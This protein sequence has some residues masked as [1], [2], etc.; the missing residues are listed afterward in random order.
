MSEKKE[1]ER[2]T[3]SS[4]SAKE[5]LSL[6]ITGPFKGPEESIVGTI[7]VNQE[8][9]IKCVISSVT[10]LINA[11]S[12][13]EGLEIKNFSQQLKYEGIRGDIRDVLNKGKII[14]K[15]VEGKNGRW[16]MLELR[17]HSPEENMDGVVITF[18]DITELKETSQILTEKIEKIKE[19]QR[20][21][22]KQDVS[23]RWRIGQFLHD[24]VGQTLVAADFLLQNVKKKL[25]AG[26]NG[27]EENIDQ[28]IEALKET[29][30][31][32]RDL[33]HEIIPIDIEKHGITQVFF[34]FGRQMAKRYN[35]QCDLEYDTTPVT[36]T[37]IE[38]ATNL[39]HIAQE[40]VK[41]AVVHGGAE[42]VEISLKSDNDYIY[43]TI[44]DDG[45]GFSDSPKEV[46]GKGVEIMRHR[47][48]LIGGTLEIK[49]TTSLGETGITVSGKLPIQEV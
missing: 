23:Q 14:K 3:T 16:Y 46:Q 42:H 12:F 19:L 33:S 37:N 6:H 22:I 32:V 20:E 38:V 41:N 9:R 30:I 31:N 25:A 24:E 4:Y 29:D 36:L 13:Q 43:I 28:V 47:M 40:S 49:N 15:E 8:N 39:Y 34:D 27:V 7:F 35:V 11:N 17:P 18:I 10:E 45:T 48:E 26:E 21:I 5:Q 2:K 44:A 1:N